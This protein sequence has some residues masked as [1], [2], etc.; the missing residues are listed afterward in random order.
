MAVNNLKRRQAVEKAERIM[1]G[2]EIVEEADVVIR[3]NRISDIGRRGNVT[4][5]SGAKV[6]DLAGMTIDE[7]ERLLIE[8][9]LAHTGNNRTRAAQL[10]DITPKTLFNK[11]RAWGS[12]E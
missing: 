8:L 11:L 3:N 5:P 6:I 7:A 12:P 10:L 2:D 1:K 9:T 4:V